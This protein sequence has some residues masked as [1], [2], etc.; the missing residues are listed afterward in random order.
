MNLPRTRLSMNTA[1]KNA[2]I[3]DEDSSDSNDLLNINFGKESIL[4]VKQEPEDA[5]NSKQSHKQNEGSCGIVEIKQETIRVK[6]E[7][8][9][10]EDTMFPCN[11]FDKLNL[12]KEAMEQY[13]S[14]VKLEM[15]DNT[16]SSMDSN[17]RKSAKRTVFPRESPYKT[18]QSP[19]KRPVEVESIQESSLYTR[20]ETYDKARTRKR[21]APEMETDPK[22]LQRRQ[23]QIDYGKNTIGYD[24]Y[25]K[26]VPKNKRSATDP[27]TPN[28]YLK[29]SRRGFDGLI[30]QWRL[31]L[32]KYDPPKME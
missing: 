9:V 29:Y 22:V 7:L 6:Q 4:N 23:K 13:L 2:R 11:V 10:D 16:N 31:K 1:L 21:K 18:R 19:Y 17:S 24:I 14:P 28:K 26:T 30:K 8:V 32:H 3:F 20:L 12:K 5:D 15:D 27:Q 25:V